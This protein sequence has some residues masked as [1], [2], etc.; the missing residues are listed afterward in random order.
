MLR[1]CHVESLLR[2]V[3]MVYLSIDL[4]YRLD[5]VDVFHF[6]EVRHILLVIARIS[7]S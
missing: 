2:D 3:E 4:N 1:M 7:D 6:V 5:C